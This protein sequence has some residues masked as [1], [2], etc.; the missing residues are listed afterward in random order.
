MEVDA[1]QQNFAR[2]DQELQQAK[3]TAEKAAKRQKDMESLLSTKR[4]KRDAQ[5]EAATAAK[6]EAEA[7]A[8]QQ[9]KKAQE[10]RVA[11][12]KKAG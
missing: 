7:A 9:A 1:D 2:W 10:E 3:E 5:M 11:A 6:L 4:R 8:A 12:A